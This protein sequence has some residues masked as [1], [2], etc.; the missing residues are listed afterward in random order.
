MEVSR[1]LDANETELSLR[2]RAFLECNRQFV[3]TLDSIRRELDRTPAGRARKREVE[4]ILGMFDR[5]IYWVSSEVRDIIEIIGQVA[6]YTLPVNVGRRP[7]VCCVCHDE[8]AF[9]KSG[10]AAMRK[11]GTPRAKH[12]MCGSCFTA[13]FIQRGESSCPVC[14]HDYESTFKKI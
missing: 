9:K 5:L 8:D 13:W 1:K 11:C 6:V 2:L 10:R 7:G 12:V 3:D 4:T 14:R